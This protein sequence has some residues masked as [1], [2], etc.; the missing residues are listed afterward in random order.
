MIARRRA[1]YDV[2]MTAADAM[3]PAAPNPCMSDVTTWMRYWP[4][5]PRQSIPGWVDDC[6]VADESTCRFEAPSSEVL[7][8]S[9][10]DMRAAIDGTPDWQRSIVS[11]RHECRAMR[12]VTWLAIPYLRRI[13]LYLNWYVDRRLRF[14][15]LSSRHGSLSLIRAESITPCPCRNRVLRMIFRTK[16]IVMVNSKSDDTEA[17]F[18]LLG[19]D[20]SHTQSCV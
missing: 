11:T 19:F 9:I 17:V 8:T 13:A 2:Y 3:D 12:G 7:T 4:T 20:A 15:I 6:D 10:D 14:R 5:R 16:P 1:T 18:F